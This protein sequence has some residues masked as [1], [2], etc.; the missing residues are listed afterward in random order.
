[1]S[2]KSPHRPQYDD[3][4][5]PPPENELLAQIRNERRYRLLLTHEYH[6]SRAFGPFYLLTYR[7][8]NVILFYS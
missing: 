2:I 1:M 3:A 4:A 5:S 6:P 8:L 7:H